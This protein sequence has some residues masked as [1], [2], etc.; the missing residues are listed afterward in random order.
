M[1]T[2]WLEFRE[3]EIERKFEKYHSENSIIFLK[4]LLYM[5][6]LLI[7]FDVIF[8]TVAICLGVNLNDRIYILMTDSSIL[9][10]VILLYIVFSLFI[11]TRL[12]FLSS[13]PIIAVFV[14]YNEYSI[15]A[16]N[17]TLATQM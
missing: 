12:T 5:M 9:I 17:K 10:L 1:L 3:E 6:I 8:F 2:K 11:K 7:I 16:Q 14:V 15:I 4:A 13:L